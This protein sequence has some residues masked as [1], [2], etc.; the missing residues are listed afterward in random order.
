MTWDVQTLD[1]AGKPVP[2]DVS[3]ALVDKAVLTL[4]DDNAG[5]LMDRFYYQRGPGRADR[6]DA[7]C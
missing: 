1:A 5:K 7:G 2:A 6:R 4:A 3:L